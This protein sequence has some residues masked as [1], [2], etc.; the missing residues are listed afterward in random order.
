VAHYGLD[1]DLVGDLQQQ[2]GSAAMIRYSDQ[3]RR[4]CRCGS[5]PSI[6]PESATDQGSN[7]A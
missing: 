2:A 6:T 7:K 5:A 4:I 3:P 1:C